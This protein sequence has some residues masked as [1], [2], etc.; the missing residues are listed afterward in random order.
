MDAV[1]QSNHSHKIE[2]QKLIISRLNKLEN[3]L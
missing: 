2:K 1:S 3:D